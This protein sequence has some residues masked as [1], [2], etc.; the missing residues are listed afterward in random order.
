M[1]ILIFFL[2][3]IRAADDS[4]NKFTIDSN[5]WGGTATARKWTASHSSCNLPC[6]EAPGTSNAQHLGSI[7]VGFIQNNQ[8]KILPGFDAQAGNTWIYPI[9][10]PIRE[11]QFNIVKN[12]LFINTLVSLPTGDFK[13]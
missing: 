8:D 2:F 7:S 13:T 12:A 1:F 6:N 5:V 4:K 10:Y 3:L 11:Y 9:N